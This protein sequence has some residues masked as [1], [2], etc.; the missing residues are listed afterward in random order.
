MQRSTGRGLGVLQFVTG[1]AF[2]LAS[3]VQT[4]RQMKALAR[5]TSARGV[6]AVMHPGW[7]TDHRRASL[8]KLLGRQ[9]PVDDR[10]GQFSEWPCAKVRLSRRH[11]DVRA[12]PSCRRASATLLRLS[13][14][15]VRIRYPDAGR[16]AAAVVEETADDRL[17]SPWRSR[18]CAHWLSYPAPAAGAAVSALRSAS[19]EHRAP[20]RSQLRATTSGGLRLEVCQGSVSVQSDLAAAR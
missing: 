8:P 5:R 3:R 11:S 16:I 10:C 7:V 13:S 1:D 14:A 15:V 9:R 4:Y 19:A 2:D 6:P 12:G 18:L 20:V 17:T